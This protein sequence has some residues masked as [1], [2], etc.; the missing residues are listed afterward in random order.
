MFYNEGSQ[1]TW[2]PKH[3]PYLLNML[4]Q[5]ILFPVA[6]KLDAHYCLKNDYRLQP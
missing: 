6:M 3:C 1:S 4:K 2:T 5:E